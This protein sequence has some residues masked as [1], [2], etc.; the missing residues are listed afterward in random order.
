MDALTVRQGADFGILTTSGGS[1]IGHQLGIERRA[2][3][4]QA[5]VILVCRLELAL[6]G[7]VAIA[8]PVRAQ[9]STKVTDAV[10]VVISNHNLARGLADLTQIA[11]NEEHPVGQHLRVGAL[12]LG[13]HAE[14]SPVDADVIALAR[15]EVLTLGPNLQNHQLAALAALRHR[16]LVGGIHR[17]EGRCLEAD[18]HGVLGLVSR[19]YGVG[20][21]VHRTAYQLQLVHQQ[22]RHEG[23]F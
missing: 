22:R 8:V 23:Q 20:D 3:L 2:A 17:P 18:I 4:D 13:S 12:L 10:D 21:I 11:A 5:P 9:L 1:S 6:D 15:E 16:L 14:V 19:L 7:L